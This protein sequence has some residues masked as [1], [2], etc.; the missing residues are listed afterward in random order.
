MG[1]KKG[2][3]ERAKKLE[4]IEPVLLLEGGLKT[5]CSRLKFLKKLSV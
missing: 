3:I 5:F 1:G 4:A 2:G